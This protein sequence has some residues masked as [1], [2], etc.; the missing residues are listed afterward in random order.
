M[1][2]QRVIDKGILTLTPIHTAPNNFGAEGSF[3]ELKK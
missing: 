1:T 2:E 3:Y